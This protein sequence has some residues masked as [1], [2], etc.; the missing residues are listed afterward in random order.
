MTVKVIHALHVPSL[1]SL[2]RTE[3]VLILNA[4][5]ICYHLVYISKYNSATFSC[6]SL[7]VLTPVENY[8]KKTNEKLIGLSVISAGFRKTLQYA[9][10]IFSVSLW[11]KRIRVV[12]TKVYWLSA[13]SWKW[14]DKVGCRSFLSSS[15]WRCSCIALI[16][17]KS[18]QFAETSYV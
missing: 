1:L 3:F 14:L 6:A 17:F 10:T 12:F 13:L 5:F 2:S 15:S 18:F 7:H 8:R 11:I 16:A 9:F 4:T